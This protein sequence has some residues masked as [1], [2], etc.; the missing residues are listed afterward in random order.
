ML[1]LNRETTSQALVLLSSGFSLRKVAK[2]IG[3]SKTTLSRYAAKKGIS[4]VAKS[5]GRPQKL[6]IRSERALV[7]FSKGE[8][9]KPRLRQQSTLHIKKTRMSQDKLLCV[10]SIEWV[11]LLC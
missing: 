8:N 2:K 10:H 7:R 11:A 3:V 6:S 9:L 5:P 4:L 1:K